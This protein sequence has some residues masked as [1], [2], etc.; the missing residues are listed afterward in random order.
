M[1]T[2]GE[3]EIGHFKNEIIQRGEVVEFTLDEKIRY[4]VNLQNWLGNKMSPVIQVLEIQEFEENEIKE[5]ISFFRFKG[6]IV[7]VDLI[8]LHTIDKNRITNRMGKL[9]K[10]SLQKIDEALKAELTQEH[11]YQIGFFDFGNKNGF[12]E[13]G[14]FRPA[15]I[16]KEKGDEFLIAPLSRQVQKQMNP[17]IQVI[18]NA[19]EGNIKDTCMVL[20]EQNTF[21]KKKNPQ[22]KITIIGVVPK[23][24]SEQIKKG[25]YKSIE[26]LPL[27]EDETS[28]LINQA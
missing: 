3:K 9:P 24:R 15:V 1:H 8:T 5:I 23:E 28:E 22:Q 17:E 12:S 13:Q 2:V 20:N 6:K 7:G 4:G 14:G 16:L 27:F 21:F 18:L 26:I 25:R 19:G 10:E 11:T